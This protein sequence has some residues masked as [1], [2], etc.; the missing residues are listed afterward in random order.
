MAEF[1]CA[2]CGVGLDS[3]EYVRRLGPGQRRD[4]F[5][6]KR[7]KLCKPCWEKDSAKGT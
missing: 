7:D 5:L 4:D 6:L 1:K 2:D 3:V